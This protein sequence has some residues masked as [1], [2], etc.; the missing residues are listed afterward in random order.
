MNRFLSFKPT[1]SLFIFLSIYTITFAQTQN[2]NKGKIVYRTKIEDDE[3]EYI[4]KDLSPWDIAVYPNIIFNDEKFKIITKN[5]EK[6]RDISF[7]DDG[8]NGDDVSGDGLYSLSE[9]TIEKLIQGKCLSES[10][11]RPTF[12]NDVKGYTHLYGGIKRGRLLV[13]DSE[14]RGTV[15]SKDF[16]NG[17][18]ATDYALFYSL[19]DEYNY[20][21]DEK[22]WEL[23]SPAYSKAGL[24]VL[25]EFGNMFDYLV[26]IPDKQ[27]GGAGYVRILDNIKGIMTY[28]EESYYNFDTGDKT[29]SHKTYNKLKG[30]IWF[31]QWNTTTLNH[32]FGH[33]VGIGPPIVDFPGSDLSW[34][35]Q[36]RMHINSSSTVS[37]VMTG[38]F[39]DPKHGWPN[40][41]RVKDEQGVWKEVQIEA[42]GDGTFT[43]VPRDPYKHERY[44]DI[45]LYMLGFKSPEEADTRYYLFNEKEMNLKDCFVQDDSKGEPLIATAGASGLYCYDDIIDQSEYGQ[46]EEF[47]VQEMINMFGP[48]VP[49]Y[50]Q[51]PKHLNIGVI[52]LTKN[53]PSEAEIV[54][55]H[56]KYEW[57]AT[58]DEWISDLGGTW[59]F[60]TRGLATISTGIPKKLKKK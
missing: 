40:S 32:E 37:N 56:L 46:I 20:V 49:S 17:L 23:H 5:P 55:N 1:F 8:T 9:V 48:R 52:Y 36:D 12:N 59:P 60:V 16:G 14:L 6:C 2:M 7:F 22:N 18:M 33:S 42:N 47:G 26:F 25:K 10:Q 53:H 45:L 54:W 28:N 51:A 38:P 43:M 50:E 58:K 57:W 31:G 35:S 34:N 24:R 39:W 15:Q 30:N 19:K 13:I 29:I 3:L 44:D 4:R 41:V 21:Y 11:F 27:F